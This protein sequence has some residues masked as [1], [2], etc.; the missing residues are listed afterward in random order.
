MFCIFLAARY[1]QSP[2]HYMQHLNTALHEAAK[3]NFVEILDLLLQHKSN[4]EL[5]NRVRFFGQD[6]SRHMTPL[7]LALLARV[8]AITTNVSPI[9]DPQVHCAFIR[10][11]SMARQHLT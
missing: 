11:D 10:L 9:V 5:R 8:N 2:V 1:I 7:R 3:N 6:P 4:V